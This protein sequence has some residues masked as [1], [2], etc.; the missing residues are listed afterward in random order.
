MDM[1]RRV[2]LAAAGSGGGGGGGSLPVTSGLYRWFKSDTG[3]TMNGSNQVSAWADQ[4]GNAGGDAA[5]GTASVAPVW[6]VAVLDGYPG[7]RFDN[8]SSTRMDVDL[9]GMVSTSYTVFIVSGRRYDG[10][11]LYA[12]GA[13]GPGDTNQ[14]LH[15]G[16]VT[17]TQWRLGQYGNDLDVT[18][19]AYSTN[20]F[21]VMMNMLDTT[22][23]H[24]V[25]VNNGLATATNS[26][27]TALSAM[28]GGGRIGMAIAGFG[29]T[30][31]IVEI[32]I[33]TRALTST[34]RGQ[35]HT[36]LSGKYPSAYA[37]LP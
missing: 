7:L 25:D 13:A 23:G 1:M 5:Q 30:G 11:Q 24:V 21:H 6:T 9:S 16:W 26:N 10:S 4:S 27:T 22:T 33:Y 17:G 28:N 31:D 3:V 37:A 15:I 35:V 14:C 8:L 12:L 32:I 36:Y 20:R 2:M 19:G 29:F 34:E 18:V